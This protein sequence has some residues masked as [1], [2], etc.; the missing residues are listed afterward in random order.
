MNFKHG[1]TVSK[2]L[3]EQRGKDSISLCAGWTSKPK[4]IFLVFFSSGFCESIRC[5]R[6]YESRY[7][8]V[9]GYETAEVCHSKLW[10]TDGCLHPKMFVGW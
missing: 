6:L 1:L 5:D 3:E 4:G 8:Y 9:M 2:L 10:W 7:F